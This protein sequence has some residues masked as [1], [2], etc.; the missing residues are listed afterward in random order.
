MLKIKNL[1]VSVEDKDILKGINFIVNFGE[2]YVIM[3]FNGFGKSILVL[4]IVGKDEF[5]VIKGSIEFEGEDIKE[6]DLEERVYK[7]VFFF[8]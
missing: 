4:V 8:F 5:E 2:V 1:Y 6:L 3:G 7:G